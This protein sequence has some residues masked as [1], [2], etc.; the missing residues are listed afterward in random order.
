M[1]V[2]QGHQVDQDPHSVGVQEQLHVV[3]VVEEFVDELEESV[4]LCPIFALGTPGEGGGRWMKGG[5]EKGLWN[6]ISGLFIAEPQ[7]FLH[8]IVNT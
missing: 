8:L 5:R 6:I 1:Q 4:S 2:S 3:S 7:V